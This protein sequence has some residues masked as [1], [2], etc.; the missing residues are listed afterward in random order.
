MLLGRAHEPLALEARRRELRARIA[1]HRL[2]IERDAQAVR[3]EAAELRSWRT[4][5]RRYPGA[6]L[7]GAMT[8]GFFFSAG[9]PRPAL[10]GWFVRFAAGR[11]VNYLSHGGADELR[12]WLSGLWSDRS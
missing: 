4:Y 7:L 12:E 11:I 8:A 2:R 3:R 10:S 9:V 6:S 5:V 1:R